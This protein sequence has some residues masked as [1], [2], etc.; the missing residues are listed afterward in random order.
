MLILIHMMNNFILL[1]LND[2]LFPI[3]GYTQSYGLET[4]VQKNIIHNAETFLHYVKNYLR[5]N[6]LYNDLL[7]VKLAFEGGL[8]RDMSSIIA[9]ETI[10]SATKIAGEIRQ[11]SQKM[12]SRFI[13]NCCALALTP[14]DS[15][16]HDYQ[17]SINT[18]EILGHH[19]VAYGV[20]CAALKLENDAVISHY[21]YAQLSGIINTGVKLIPLSQTQGQKILTQLLS[22]L[23]NMVLILKTL[24]IEALGR[25]SPG[26]ELRAMQ[27]ADLYSRLYMS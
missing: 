14:T 17:N 22:E 12:G 7:A 26:F 4:Y 15:I 1:Q 25:S 5:Y 11:A 10:L 19:A 21:L 20:F 16:F 13:K 6:V 18:K 3:G 9:I 27:H 24:S 23:E 8:Q 2:S